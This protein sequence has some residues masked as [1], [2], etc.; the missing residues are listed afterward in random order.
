M[1][2]DIHR[3][4]IF[5][6]WLTFVTVF[7]IS[8]FAWRKNLKGEKKDIISVDLYLNFTQIINPR[9]V[10]IRKRIGVFLQS[11]SIVVAFLY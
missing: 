11:V 6:K 8:I 10:R 9:H 1:E 3:K 2:F 7:A 4:P 5:L